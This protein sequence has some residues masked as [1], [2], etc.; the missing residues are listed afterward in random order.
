M[1]LL[2]IR[3]ET[4]SIKKLRQLISDLASHS[5]YLTLILIIIQSELVLPVAY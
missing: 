2:L 5:T 1:G 4:T 3:D